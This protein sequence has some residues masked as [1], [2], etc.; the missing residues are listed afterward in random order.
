M[1][2]YLVPT[3]RYGGLAL[4]AAALAYCF[5]VEHTRVLNAA[6]GASKSRMMAFLFGFI[7]MLIVFAVVVAYDVSHFLGR[8]AE[9]SFLQ[10]GRPTSTATEFEE[11]ERLRAEGRPLDAIG[12]L[13][14]YLQ[15]HPDETEVMGRIAEIY[16][17]SLKN[18]LAAALEY[19][20]MLKRKLPDEQWAWAALHLA[21]CYGR[22]NEP[23]KSLALLQ[24]LDAEYGQTV[25]AKRARKALQS[26]QSGDASDPLSSSEV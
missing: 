10:G 15:E 7:V 12:V 26:L 19:E 25:A 20:E 8:H 21:K 22:L 1:H 6:A 14:E 18:Y 11:A 3:L 4:C 5:S 16:N 9:L 23:E 2:R 24:R 13:R 17:H